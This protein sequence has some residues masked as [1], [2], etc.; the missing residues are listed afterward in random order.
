MIKVILPIKL[1]E[2]PLS[3]CSACFEEVPIMEE[4]N[5]EKKFNQFFVSIIGK[6]FISMRLT[7][8]SHVVFCSEHRWRVMGRINWVVKSMHC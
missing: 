4:K 2:K 3:L 1:T 7:V 8:I 5:Q 6:A